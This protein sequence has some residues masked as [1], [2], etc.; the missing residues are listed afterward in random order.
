MN[1]SP[2]PVPQRA[3]GSESVLKV[4]KWHTPF[5]EDLSKRLAAK[6]KQSGTRKE[7]LH[8]WRHW[9]FASKAHE[10]QQLMVPCNEKSVLVG[11]EEGNYYPMF[12]KS[13]SCWLKGQAAAQQ[14][15]STFIKL[16]RY[17]FVLAAVQHKLI[18][19]KLNITVKFWNINLCRFQ[20]LANYVKESSNCFRPV[21]VWYWNFLIIL[22]KYYFKFVLALFKRRGEWVLHGNFFCSPFF[23]TW[24]ITLWTLTILNAIDTEWRSNDSPVLAFSGSRNIRSFWTNLRLWG[25]IRFLLLW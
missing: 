4:W 8:V 13:C 24:A 18:F 17:S 19:H 5:V 16:D 23:K 22:F 1:W 7:T 6:A 20:C 25:W 9:Y 12:A 10:F 11:I 2:L 14:R 21:H 3:C 15:R